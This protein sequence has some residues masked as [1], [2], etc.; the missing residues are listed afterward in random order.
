VVVVLDTHAWVWW[1]GGPGAP[2][3]G[4]K[5]NQAIGNASRLLVSAASCV[6]V[7]WLAAA[8]RL[9]LDRDVLTWQKQALAKPRVELSP[10]LPEVAVKAASLQWP[11]RDANDRIIVATALLHRASLVTKDKQIR[12]AGL[13]TTL[14]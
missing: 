7:A 13:V 8:G 2:S 5:A 4:K 6:E 12:A 14:W 3:I 1:I 10:I 9:Q 11:H